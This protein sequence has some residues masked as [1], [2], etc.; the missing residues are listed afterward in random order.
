MLWTKAILYNR[1]FPVHRL[2]L[3]AALSK[4]KHLL[5]KHNQNHTWPSLPKPNSLYRPCGPPRTLNG[6]RSPSLLLLGD[7][8]Y[9]IGIC[10]P[11]VVLRGRV[12]GDVYSGRSFPHF[13]VGSEKSP[14]E[15]FAWVSQ[16]LGMRHCRMRS[17]ALL[18]DI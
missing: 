18:D 10:F 9:E 1:Y 5:N 12:H 8:V 13:Q 4:T 17:V 7:V 14:N 3:D 2:P 6:R 16:S 15:S 11:V